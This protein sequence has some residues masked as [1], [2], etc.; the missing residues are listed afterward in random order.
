VAIVMIQQDVVQLAALVLERRGH[1]VTRHDTWLEHRATKFT[2]RPRL[3]E[4]HRMKDGGVRS[5]STIT[6]SH[7]ELAPNGIFEFQHAT[8]EDAV[9]ALYRGFDDWAQLD[10]VVLMDA[11]RDEPEHCATFELTYPPREGMAP[12]HRRAL[13]GPVVHFAP[14]A[15]AV[16]GG[17]KED[18]HSF[19][20]CCLLTNTFE[21]FRPLAEGDGFFGVRLVAVRDQ[22]G[23]PQ[24][25]CRVNGEDWEV[26]AQALRDYVNRWPQS[27]YELRKQYVVLQDLPK[28]QTA[29]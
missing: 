13:L 12:L 20:P 19:C 10:L 26:G 3:T 25:D 18:D 1:A 4:L 29:K 8:G 7:P 15:A 27:G 11:E 6:T 9:I 16:A 22:T 24:A 21:A 17:S 5:V 14:G 28:R 2:F 23:S